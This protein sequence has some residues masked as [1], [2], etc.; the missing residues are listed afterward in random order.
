MAPLKK[1]TSR[2][3][4]P[5]AT[6]KAVKKPLAKANTWSAQSNYTKNS[7]VYKLP[8]TP[9]Q[10]KAFNK[11]PKDTLFTL[12]KGA[13]KLSPEEKKQMQAARIRDRKRT[14]ARGEAI[15]RREVRSKNI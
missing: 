8:M 5:R 12:P 9:A 2:K 7:A 4:A 14:L 11:L 10:E 1:A 13:T 15:I 3:P 6:T